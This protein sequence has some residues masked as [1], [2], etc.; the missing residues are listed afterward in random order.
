MK[1]ILLTLLAFIALPVHAASWVVGAGVSQSQLQNNGTWWQEG[2]PHH[3]VLTQPALEVGVTGRWTPRMDWQVAA[4]WLGHYAVSSLDTPRDS[5]YNADSPTHCNGPCLPLA[6]YIG[7]GHVWGVQAL[8]S[9]HTTGAW[10]FGVEAGP[11]LYHSDWRLD[12]PDW[13]PPG[14]PITPVATYGSRWALGAVVGAT[15]SHGRWTAALRYYRD[16]AGF[17]GHVGH[18]PPLWQGQVVGVLEYRL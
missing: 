15:L 6:H 11:W 1:T 18:W 10:R 2:F 12:V 9:R 5:N 13:Y 14:G 16:D 3:F 17:P 8:V 4:V 7:N